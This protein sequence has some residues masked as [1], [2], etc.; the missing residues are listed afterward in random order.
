MSVETVAEGVDQRCAIEDDFGLPLGRVPEH[1]SQRTRLQL[2]EG[3]REVAG[4]IR[5]GRPAR[6]VSHAGGEEPIQSALEPER[7]FRPVLQGIQRP[8]QHRRADALR[9]QRQGSHAS[10]PP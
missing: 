9:I 3:G 8:L 2:L 5:E 6:V 4:R 1:D 10:R 7:V